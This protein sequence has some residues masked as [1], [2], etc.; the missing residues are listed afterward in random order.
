MGQVVKM[1]IL[2]DNGTYEEVK[3][4]WK[5]NSNSNVAIINGISTTMQT[6]QGNW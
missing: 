1:Y 3:R 6:V 2:L 4:N 5:N